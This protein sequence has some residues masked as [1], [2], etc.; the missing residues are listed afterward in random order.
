MSSVWE[1]SS[2]YYHWIYFTHIHF[3][4]SINDST[5]RQTAEAEAQDAMFIL[6]SMSK[7]TLAMMSHKILQRSWKFIS[8]FFE[9]ATLLDP[10][11]CLHFLARA[12]NFQVCFY[13]GIWIQGK[14]LKGTLEHSS[15][16][17]LPGIMHSLA[18]QLWLR[19]STFL[20]LSFLKCKW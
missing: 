9:K 13:F 17:R 11:S 1:A 4:I 15:G 2:T 19:W 7:M 10:K 3:Q 16:V 6:V 14:K 12:S 18:M 5:S 20:W 8:Q